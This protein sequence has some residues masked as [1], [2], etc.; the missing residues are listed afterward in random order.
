[1]CLCI[2]VIWSAV[3]EKTPYQRNDKLDRKISLYSGDITKLEI[4]AIVNAG[5][6]VFQRISASNSLMN[7]R[8]SG[9]WRLCT[10]MHWNS[11]QLKHKTHLRAPCA[12]IVTVMIC[13]CGWWRLPAVTRLYVEA[14]LHKVYRLYP[15]ISEQQRN[16]EW[17]GWWG[18]PWQLQREEKL[19]E[20]RTGRSEPSL[21]SE[22]TTCTLLRN[23]TFN[24]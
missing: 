21:S 10:V 13:L 15:W 14:S 3:S 2:S 24:M 18:S 5:K 16:L 8:G 6:C 1:M 7:G 22:Q 17:G 23:K 11:K 19:P 9:N 20:S 12:N 4:D